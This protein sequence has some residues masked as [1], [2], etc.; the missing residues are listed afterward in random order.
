MIIEGLPKLEVLPQ[1]L[2]G[3]ANTLQLLWIGECENFTALPEWLPRLES[4]HTLTIGK[5]PKLSCL[6]EGMEALTTLRQLVIEGCPNLSR[7][8]REEDSHKIAHVPKIVLD[9]EI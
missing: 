8:C 2:Q 4:L 6:P 7:K 5:C 1:W 3:F 9:E